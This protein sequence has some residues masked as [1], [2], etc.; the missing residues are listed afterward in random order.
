MK[1]YDNEH[2]VN[3]VECA[4]ENDEEQY[5]VVMVHFD[6]E[7]LRLDDLKAKV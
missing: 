1:K 7:Q 5:E 2:L 3:W 4:M 6:M